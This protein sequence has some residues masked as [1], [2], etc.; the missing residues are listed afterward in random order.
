V[1]VLRDGRHVRTAAIAETDRDR[2]IQDMIG[3]PWTGA[4]PARRTALGE[5]L[6]E[7]D[8]L[9]SPGAFRPVSFTLHAGEV[10]GLTGLTGSGKQELGRALFGAHPVHAGTVRLRG[11]PLRRLSPQVAIRHSLAF[12]PDDRKSEGVIQPLSVRRNVSLPV[13]DSLATWFGHIRGAQERELARRWVQRLDIRTSSLEQIC[14]N[15]SGGNQQKVALAKWLASRAQVLILAEPTQGID[16]G[17]KFEIYRLLAELSAQG[18]GVLLISSEIPELLG[19]C[20]SILVMR[21]GEVVARLPAAVTDRETVLRHSLGQP[22]AAQASVQVK[23][24]NRGGSA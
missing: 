4:F 16:V 7:V 20:H 11:Q 10:L 13:L 3:R 15:L 5:S 24:A 14:Q 17:V 9:S 19:L 23:P 1:T 8:G 2:L 18:V 6:L 22:N 12:I 21:D